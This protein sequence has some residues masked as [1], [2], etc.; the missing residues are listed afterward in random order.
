MMSDHITEET[1]PVDTIDTLRRQTE[2]LQQELESFRGKARENAMLADLKV[3]A[4]RAGMIDLDGIKLLDLSA[5]RA[6]EDGQVPEAS[7]L[8]LELKR[9]KPWL[10][11]A[12]STSSIQEAP[13][14]QPPRQKQA[15]EMS[16]DEYHAARALVLKR[17][18]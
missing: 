14:Y 6:A 10:F 8:M 2:A 17:R 7:S 1:A 9:N 4:I 3:A 16:D 13:P 12:R 18:T 11:G 5:V 15:M